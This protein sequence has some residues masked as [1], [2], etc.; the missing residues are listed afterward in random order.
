VLLR[1]S[2]CNVIIP[3]NSIEY[4]FILNTSRLGVDFEYN[5]TCL[6]V[7]VR[8]RKVNGNDNAVKRLFPGDIERRSLAQFLPNSQNLQH[9]SV[10]FFFKLESG[11]LVY[12][13]SIGD[14]GMCR[15]REAQGE[16]PR[17]HDLPYN[18]VSTMINLYQ[19]QQLE[20]DD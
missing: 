18:T 14:D 7:T 1:T 12:V 16:F 19:L 3:N 2:T 10:N 6:R 9:V 8:Y 15:C 5:G 17:D 13:V 4:P 11:E 20:L